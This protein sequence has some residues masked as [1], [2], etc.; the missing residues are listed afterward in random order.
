M[1]EIYYNNYSEIKEL[2]KRTAKSLIRHLTLDALDL[3]NWDLQVLKRKRIQFIYIHHTFKDELPA[4]RILIEN[5]AKSHTFISHSEAVRILTSGEINKPYISFSSDDGFRNNLDAA[6]VFN[7]YGIKCCFFVCPGIVAETRY[8]TIK[9][10]CADRLHLPPVEF[11]DWDD[12]HQ[13]LEHGHEIGGHTSNH[14]DLGKVSQSIA[15]DE[16]FSCKT[17]LDKYCGHVSHFAYPY[18]RYH[19]FPTSLKSSIYAAGFISNS[20]AERGCHVLAPGTRVGG[21][22]LLIRRDHVILDW[23]YGHIR[24]FLLNNSRKASVKGNYYP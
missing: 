17:S 6:K 14:V 13:L 15:E 21:Q 19:N 9:E 8:D 22:D 12:I 23:P 3:L 16:I 20:S 24:Y 7:E 5:L 11:L 18:G 4:L 1:A 10:F 2:G